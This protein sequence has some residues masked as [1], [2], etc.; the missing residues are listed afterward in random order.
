M[1]NPLF[2][3]A[4]LQRCDDMS[5][6]ILFFCRQQTDFRQRKCLCQTGYKHVHEGYAGLSAHV[7][8]PTWRAARV[9][10]DFFVACMRV[11]EFYACYSFC[12]KSPRW[13]ISP[14]L[15]FGDGFLRGA[16]ACLTR[17]SGRRWF[18]KLLLK[19]MLPA[20][21]QTHETPLTITEAVST[22]SSPTISLHCS[23]QP[24][25]CHL[26]CKAKLVADQ[27]GKDGVKSE[28][29]SVLMAEPRIAMVANVLTSPT[30]A[31]LCLATS[32]RQT[33]KRW[34]KKTPWRTKCP[35]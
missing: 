13:R 17:P 9:V 14:P 23:L 35:F 12:G 6:S 30:R 20:E 22:S 7:H 2:F 32:A 27:G 8:R 29:R 34:R 28:S 11:T 18:T 3:C 25:V 33:P 24:L 16:R 19:P 1:P 26:C 31:C 15:V 21:V 5:A 10:T 4:R